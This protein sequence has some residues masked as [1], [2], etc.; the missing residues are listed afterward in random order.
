MLDE[1]ADTGATHV[2]IAWVWWQD[3]LRATSIRAVDGW[4]ATDAQIADAMSY[5]KKLGL[6][7][8][9]FPILRLVKTEK[10]DEWRGTIAPSDEDAWWQSYRTVILRAA[11][12]AKESGADRLCIGSELLSRERQRAQWQRLIEETR[13]GAPELELIYS[14]NWDHFREVSFWDLVDVVGLTAYF[15]LTR[16]NEATADELTLAWSGVRAIISDF[17][18]KIG[19]KVVITELGYPSID[20]AAAYPW[21]ETRETAIDLEE[22]RRAYEAFARS[23]SNAR[24]LQGVYFWNWFGHGGPTDRSYTPKDK[25]AE[26]IIRAWYRTRAL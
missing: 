24:A 16:S 9:A 10:R 21:D 19:R 3:D 4:S 6:H 23:W 18:L 5:A 13:L 15:E 22:Q 8:M 14:A 17:S 7:V 25:P 26:A 11:K 20:G 1:L 2:S 12:L